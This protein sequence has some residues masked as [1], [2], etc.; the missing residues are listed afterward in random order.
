[1]IH[2]SGEDYLESILML[3]QQK[4]FARSVDIAEHHGYSKASVSRAMAN[5]KRDGFITIGPKGHILLTDT[6]AARAGEIYER[7]LMLRH[8]LEKVLG[9]PADIAEEDACRIE[10]V[11]SPE[12]FQSMQKMAAQA[13]GGKR[14]FKTTQPAEAEKSAD[15]ASNGDKK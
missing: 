3:Q 5:L 12:T 4:G 2:R 9:V 8:Y 6:G 13:A 7:H 11:I 15:N 1:M 10:H 14:L